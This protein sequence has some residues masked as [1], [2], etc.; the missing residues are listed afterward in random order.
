M[1]LLSLGEA[2]S[3]VDSSLSDAA[4]QILLDAAEQ[5]ITL[6]AGGSGAVT[7]LISAGSGD[8]VMLSRPASAVSAITERGETLASNDYV[9]NGRTLRR[10]TGG[11]H[12]SSRWR[13]RISVTY[14]PQDET[15]VRKA[16]QA[17]LLKLELNTRTGTQSESIGAWSE[18]FTSGDTYTAER[19]AILRR[20]RSSTLVML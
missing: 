17:S 8:L 1:T 2:K 10:V 3:L 19:Q 6:Y 4:L 5:A 16:V 7:E 13:G 9:L 14:T 15:E 20:L 12:P 11:T 18:T